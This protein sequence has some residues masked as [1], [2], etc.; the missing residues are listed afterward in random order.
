MVVKV[1]LV[2]DA[3]PERLDKIHKTLK[4]FDE[5]KFSCMVDRGPNDIVAMI[6]VE[7]LNDY[8]GLIERV[9]AIPHTED[10]SSFIDTGT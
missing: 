1:F 2:I 7:D 3:Q 8:R 5:V 4:G 10:F 6:E 9:A